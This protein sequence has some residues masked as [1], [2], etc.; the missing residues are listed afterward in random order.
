M[1][2]LR[3]SSRLCVLLYP[4]CPLI[5]FGPS[6]LFAAAYAKPSRLVVCNTWSVNDLAAYDFTL[7]LCPYCIIFSY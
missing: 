7:A 6:H 3:A 1:P 5:G 4:T 2:P